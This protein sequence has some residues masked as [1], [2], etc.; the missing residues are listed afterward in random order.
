MNNII[1]KIIF[2]LILFT[3]SVFAECKS[4]NESEIIESLEVEFYKQSQFIEHVS[5][6]YISEKTD[7]YIKGFNKKKDL[8]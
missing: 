8:M 7:N 4:N 5:I 6:F 3:S 2:F 1:A